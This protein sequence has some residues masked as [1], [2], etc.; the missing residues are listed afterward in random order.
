MKFSI[1]GPRGRIANAVLIA[2]QFLD[3]RVDFFDGL[4]FPHFIGEATGFLRH[5][6]QSLLAP[7]A[8]SSENCSPDGTIGLNM[9]GKA[10]RV[11]DSVRPLGKF[12][13]SLDR[14]WI[15]EGDAVG[16]Q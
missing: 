6:M 4:P 13:G 14:Y 3:V 1:I 5:A 11:D 16:K 2:K 8:G 7:F 10:N 15:L 9:P 12:D